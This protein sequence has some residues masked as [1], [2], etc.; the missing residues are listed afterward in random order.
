MY[1]V[2]MFKDLKILKFL[3]FEHFKAFIVVVKKKSTRPVWTAFKIAV[4][5]KLPTHYNT[6]LYTTY[7]KGNSNS[8]IINKDGNMNEWVQKKVLIHKNKKWPHF[9]NS[10]FE[11]YK[12]LILIEV[13]FI[14]KY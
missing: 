4:R 12:N 6:R 9:L 7:K 5:H 2:L 1:K 8:F 10:S 3:M 14:K 13:N 11:L